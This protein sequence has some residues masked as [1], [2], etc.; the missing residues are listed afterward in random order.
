[1]VQG[2]ETAVLP[3]SAV[4][5]GSARPIRGVALVAVGNSR[6]AAVIVTALARRLEGKGE[7]VLLV[8]LSRSGDLTSRRGHAEA[9]R[10]P[11][12][13]ALARGPL[14]G[15]QAR[16]PQ[17]EGDRPPRQEADVVLV[18]ADVLPGIDAENLRTWVTQVVPLVTSGQSSAELLETTSDLV[19][20]AGLDMP[21][22]LMLGSDRT[23]ESLGVP[24][25]PASE[26][27]GA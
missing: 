25:V 21:F 7:R 18:L 2:L 15:P 6:A 23:D 10:P 27:T 11:A 8:D 1:M 19:R 14:S 20:A 12:P 3:S 4:A 16:D 13:V 26:L 24:D 22:A 9:Y 5:A 17:D